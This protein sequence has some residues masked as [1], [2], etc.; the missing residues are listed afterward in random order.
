MRQ[1][2]HALRVPGL[3]FKCGSTSNESFKFEHIS[4]GPMYQGS[5][6]L[7]VVPVAN[8]SCWDNKAVGYCPAFK[9][10]GASVLVAR[11]TSNLRPYSPRLKAPLGCG[12]RQ[13]VSQAGESGAFLRKSPHV[14]AL[15][16]CQP[17]LPLA[18]DNAESAPTMPA[19]VTR[20]DASCWAFAGCKCQLLAATVVHPRSDR[21]NESGTISPDLIVPLSTK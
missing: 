7:V 10:V 1:L 13:S 2:T 18:P 20:A 3:V 8:R 9:L 14:V 4:A 12:P 6:N 5:H 11:V 21:S 17:P 19:F 15:L 16:L